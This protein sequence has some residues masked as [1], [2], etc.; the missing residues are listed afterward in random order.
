[1]MSLAICTVLYIIVVA[2]LNGMVP[3]NTLNVTYPVSFALNSVGLAWAGTIIA[4]GAIGGLTTVLLVMM[5]GQTRVFYAMSR[6]G[7]IPPLFV[8]LHPTWRTPA[9]SQ[10]F[11]GVCIAAAAAFFPI[12]VLTSL[13]NMGTFVAF[14]L[15]SIAVPLLRNRHPE[16]VGSF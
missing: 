10:I 4:F 16:M 5:Y 7:L 1:L 2:I 15:V 14:I 11:F 3:F 6:D 8:K 9:A 12:G 13:T